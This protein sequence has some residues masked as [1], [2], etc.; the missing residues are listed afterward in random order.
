M[1]RC[2]QRSVALA[3]L[4][5]L[6]ANVLFIASFHC[7]ARTLWDTE[8]GNSV[9]SLTQHLLIVPVG[10]VILMVPLFP[11]G[12]GIGELGF[13]G[14][15]AWFHCTAA[16]GVLALLV[17][18]VIGWVVG[19]LGFIVYSLPGTRATPDA[20]PVTPLPIDPV[21]AADGIPH[22]V[23]SERECKDWPS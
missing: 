23:D 12:A 5:S 11:G 1:Y 9:P 13:G 4:L 10:M 8:P 14:L 6:I 3:F 19:L 2:R 18:R 20:E 15:Y 16:N 22:T 7:A 21:P 17:V